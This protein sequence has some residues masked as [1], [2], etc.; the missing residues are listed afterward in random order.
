VRSSKRGEVLCRWRPEQLGTFRKRRRGSQAADSTWHRVDAATR[1]LGP[2][3][4]DAMFAHYF[5]S[6]ADRKAPWRLALVSRQ[7]S[8]RQLSTSRGCCGGRIDWKYALGL[9]SAIPFDASVLSSSGVD[10][11]RRSA[12]QHLLD[13]CSRPAAR[14]RYRGLER[15]LGSCADATRQLATP[16]W[17]GWDEPNHNPAFS[18]RTPPR[19]SSCPKSDLPAYQK[20]SVQNQLLPQ[21]SGL[22]TPKTVP[23]PPGDARHRTWK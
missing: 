1:V 8:S 9:H 2:L 23:A 13:T 14:G 10:C 15:P 18:I 20:N 11:W 4:E 22:M 5:R 21:H 16:E 12:E 7:A 17:H 3:Y 6:V 19:F